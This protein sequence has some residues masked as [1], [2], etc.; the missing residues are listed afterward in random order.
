[1]NISWFHVYPSTHICSVSQGVCQDDAFKCNCT[2]ANTIEKCC[3]KGKS[4]GVV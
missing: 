3:E 4:L 1:M 2:T